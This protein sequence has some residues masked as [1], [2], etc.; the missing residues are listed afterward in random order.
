[1]LKTVLKVVKVIIVAALFKVV[2][3]I[4]KVISEVVV[5]A[6][7]LLCCVVAC[8][9]VWRSQYR[10]LRRGQGFSPGAGRRRGG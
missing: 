8:F 3:V 1:M 7:S 10:W 9:L 6:L 5:F 4:T 2:K